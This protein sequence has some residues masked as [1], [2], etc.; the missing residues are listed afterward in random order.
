MGDGAQRQPGGGAQ[1]EILAAPIGAARK[2]QRIRS[3]AEASHAE[4]WFGH[5]IAQL[6]ALRKASEGWY[7]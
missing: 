1:A 2:I 3:M 6:E 7:E 4:V 5:D